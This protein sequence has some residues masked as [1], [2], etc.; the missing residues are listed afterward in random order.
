MRGGQDVG[1]N[2]ISERRACALDHGI[3]GEY[4]VRVLDQAARFRGYPQAVRTDR[5]PEFTSRAFMAWAQSKGVRH[6]LHQPGKPTQNSYIESFNGK[7][8]DEFLNENWFQNLKQARVEIARW[9]TDYN[10]VRPH[11]SWARMPP[12]KFAARH[13][14]AT[15][16]TADSGLTSFNAADSSNRLVRSRGRSVGPRLIGAMNA[17]KG[18]H[19]HRALYSKTCTSMGLHL[20]AK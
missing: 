6:I 8:R 4:V 15:G 17:V 5:G 16:A 18:H 14:Q 13:R 1:G 3:G 12:A 2:S 20:R 19:C 11:S 7:F 10:E 9:R